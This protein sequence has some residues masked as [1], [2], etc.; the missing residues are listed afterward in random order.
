[1]GAVLMTEDDR[2]DDQ[3]GRSRHDVRRR[4][5]RRER[6]EPRPRAPVRSGAAPARFDKRR[7]VRQ[8]AHRARASH[9]PHSRRARHGLHVGHRRHGNGVARGERGVRGRVCSL[10]SAGEYTVRLLPPLVATRDE[11]ADGLRILEEICETDG[12]SSI[13]RARLE[14]AEPIVRARSPPSPTRRSC[15]GGRRRW[16]SWRS[17]TM[18]SLSTPGAASSRAAR[19]RST[20]RRSPRSPRS[21]CRAKC[22]GRGRPGDRGGGR[23]AGDQA[24]HLRRVRADAAAGVLRRDRISAGRP[25]AIS[26]EDSARL[27]G[28]R[29]PFRVQ[30]D[31]LRQESSGRRAER[32]PRSRG[33]RWPRAIGIGRGDRAPS[34]RTSP[35]RLTERRD[36]RYI[37]RA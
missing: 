8:T 23:G 12:A 16:S 30:R 11:L 6:R 20:R 18:S 33:G 3:A 7:V 32:R 14:D 5:V 37:S 26:G 25:R 17:T 24:R 4:A 15:F 9:G 1:M 36:G 10:A 31:L 19:S 13:R 29:A 34:R 27:P 22:T 2:V 35:G 21:P 28:V